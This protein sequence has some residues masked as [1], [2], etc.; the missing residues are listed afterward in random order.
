MITIKSKILNNYLCSGKIFLL[1][2]D[3]LVSK[4]FLS[5]IMLLILSIM[6]FLLG[7]VHIYIEHFIYSEINFLASFVSFI[8]IYCLRIISKKYFFIMAHILFIVFFILIFITFLLR[9]NLFPIT[10]WFLIYLMAIFFIFNTKTVV[11]YIASFFSI[12]LFIVVRDNTFNNIEFI[13]NFIVPSILGYIFIYVYKMKTLDVLE[14]LKIINQNLEERIKIETISRTKILENEKAHYTYLA[15]HDY[16]TGLPNIAMIDERLDLLLKDKYATRF[17]LFYIDLNG[18]KRINDTYGHKFGN[19]VIKE[20]SSKLVKITSKENIVAR[21][22]G[23]EFLVIVSDFTKEAQLKNIAQSYINSIEQD[24]KI[25]SITITMSC[26]LGIS[27]YPKSTRNKSDLIVYADRAMMKAKKSKENNYCF[28]PVEIN[29]LNYD[30]ISLER[31]LREAIKN[32]EFILYFQPQVDTITNIIVG[33]ET[34]VRWEHQTLGL[35]YPEYFLYLL[36]NIGL[37]LELE[38]FVIQESMKTIVEWK[39]K[40][41]FQGRIS[42]NLTIQK[43]EDKNFLKDIE[44]FLLLTGCKGEWIEFEIT[45][46]EIISSISKTI[47]LFE[48]LKKM[49]ISI[50]IDDFGIGY[51]SL[52]YLKKLTIDKIKI[53]KIF[54][55]NISTEKNYIVIID[56][57]LAIAKSFDYIVVT[58]GVENKEQRDY[59]KMHGCNIM[60][61]YYYYKPMPKDEIAKL[62]D[63]NI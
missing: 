9:P 2:E 21:I 4:Y 35:I 7:I 19:S 44:N 54:V 34:L 14:S 23:D 6:L 27:I 29:D 46:T 33:M 3:E 26:S 5:N 24:F 61:G 37:I 22:G 32:K 38:N 12:F 58:E 55:H 52:S 18:F 13:G 40:Y 28:Y 53:D 11:I 1:S 30:E 57:I 51:S 56:A 15:H 43:L 10:T 20:I 16:L 63:N 48:A 50:A 62:L 36:K 59:L 60:Q 8:A 25:N 42:I 41:Q 17:A 45:E 49:N 31:D 47:K 39:N